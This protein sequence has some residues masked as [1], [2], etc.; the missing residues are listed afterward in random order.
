MGLV[1]R[2]REM[3][4]ADQHNVPTDKMREKMRAK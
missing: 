1:S 4:I 2:H 3:V